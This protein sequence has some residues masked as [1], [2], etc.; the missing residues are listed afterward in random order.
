VLVKDRPIRKSFRSEPGRQ[1]RK[2]RT[3]GRL[4]SAQPPQT[5][6]A[7]QE[8]LQPHVAGLRRAGDDNPHRGVSTLTSAGELMAESLTSLSDLIAELLED[9]AKGAVGDGL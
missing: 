5:V 3:L 7:A 1:C 6:R 8:T 4:E 2:V 9:I